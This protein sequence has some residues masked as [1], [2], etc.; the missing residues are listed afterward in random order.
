MCQK[1]KLLDVDLDVLQMLVLHQC[2]HLIEM[3]EEYSFSVNRYGQSEHGLTL[4]SH[5]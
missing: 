5:I 3:N 4:C 2:S 1:K